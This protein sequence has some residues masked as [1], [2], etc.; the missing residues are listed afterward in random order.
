MSISAHEFQEFSNFGLGR[1][2]SSS[3]PMSLDDLVLEWESLRHRTE[4]NASI[5]QGLDDVKAG[6]HRPAS[7]VLAELRSK[8][9]APG[10]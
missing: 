4:I 6:R 3:E 5:Q 2:A 8:L 7:E 10:E 1:L 9:G